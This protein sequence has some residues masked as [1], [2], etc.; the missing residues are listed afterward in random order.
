MNFLN[1]N[2]FHD[3]VLFS[4][5]AI[6]IDE[7]AKLGLGERKTIRVSIHRWLYFC[8]LR[9]KTYLTASLG[10]PKHINV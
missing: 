1:T 4:Y 5:V 6:E 8:T 2:I 10:L 7:M 9:L 3:T